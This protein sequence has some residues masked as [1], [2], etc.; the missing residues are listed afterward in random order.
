MVGTPDDGR[1]GSRSVPGALVPARH[2]MEDG[3]YPPTREPA[4]TRAERFA[5]S[6]SLGDWVLAD[7]MWDVS[8]L[9]LVRPER[10]HAI[11]VSWRESGEYWGGTSTS[12]VPWYEQRGPCRPWI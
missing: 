10:W 6:L 5:V 2:T 3:D 1:R 4:L 12:S 7:F 9:V 8:T 11:W